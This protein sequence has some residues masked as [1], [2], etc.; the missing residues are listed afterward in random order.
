MNAPFTYRHAET[1]R[2]WRDS[3]C[4]RHAAGE[5]ETRRGLRV[6]GCD[7]QG[8]SLPCSGETLAGEHVTSGLSVLARG[9]PVDRV[10][11]AIPPACR[12]AAD[13]AGQAAR[14]EGTDVLL[15]TPVWTAAGATHFVPSFSALTD[16]P[17]GVRLELA[18][19]I[20]GAWTP[21]IAGAALGPDAFE[22][23]ASSAPLDV[24]IDVFRSTTPVEAV[25]VRA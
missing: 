20:A 16:A 10:T 5:G 8:I 3:G 4:K 14:V 12:R 6:R 2:T 19:R 18:A 24:D 9:L 11:A 7:A 25:R 23:L 21:W 17:Y 22:P 1:R 15:E 13:A